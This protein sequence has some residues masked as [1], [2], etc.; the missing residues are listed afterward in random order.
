MA[1]ALTSILIDEQFE[2]LSRGKRTGTG[3]LGNA[4]GA[5][6]VF[7]A[8]LELRRGGRQLNRGLLL[9]DRQLVC[10]I[11]VVLTREI[12]DFLSPLDHSLLSLTIVW[13]R[14]TGPLLRHSILMM[15]EELHFCALFR[16]T[17]DLKALLR[18]H[19]LA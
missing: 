7:G 12:I 17:D 19:L 4:K 3:H 9:V 2:G 15:S 13:V 16:M 5:L 18:A 14:R 11:R 6:V 1:I 8:H 10:A